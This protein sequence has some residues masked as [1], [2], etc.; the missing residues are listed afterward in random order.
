MVLDPE[1]MVQSL[2]LDLLP[3]TPEMTDEELAWEKVP[4]GEQRG[5]RRIGERWEGKMGINRDRREG[6]TQCR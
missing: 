1:G 4:G 2:K 6:P 5:K 3:G